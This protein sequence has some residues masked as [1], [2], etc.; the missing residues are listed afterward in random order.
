M[1]LS[2]S[3]T[4]MEGVWRSQTTGESRHWLPPSG[5]G[6]WRCVCMRVYVRVC[7]RPCMCVSYNQSPH[8][9]LPL[10]IYVRI[11]LSQIVEWLLGHVTHLP[12]EP[13]CHKS[14]M[15]PT[16]DKEVLL[17]LRSKC[18]DMIMKVCSYA[19]YI[20]TYVCMYAVLVYFV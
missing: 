4:R 7:M 1:R 11:H 18:L 6:T 17:P 13:E 10:C 20:R 14:L 9:S 16:G 15:A 12:S 2:S 8:P 19:L 3:Y 5:M